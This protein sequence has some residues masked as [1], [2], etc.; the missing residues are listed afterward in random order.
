M[1]TT[2]VCLL[3]CFFGFVSDAFPGVAMAGD[4]SSAPSASA[5]LEVVGSQFGDKI[6]SGRPVGDGKSA[7][8]VTYF[9]ELKNP[10]DTSAV[11]LPPRALDQGGRELKKDVL[12]R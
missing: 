9:V 8:L 4:E 2:R 10:G 6:E 7:S 12:E 11:V 5:S 3:S 1:K